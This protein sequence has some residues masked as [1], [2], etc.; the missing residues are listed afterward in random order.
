VATGGKV[1][2]ATR[3]IGHRS[4]IVAPIER[5]NRVSAL[6]VSHS[7]SWELTSAPGS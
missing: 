3:S 2:I 4:A 5:T 6:V 7:V 1:I